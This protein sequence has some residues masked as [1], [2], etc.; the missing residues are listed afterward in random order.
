MSVYI[1]IVQCTT[2]SFSLSLSLFTIWKLKTFASWEHGENRSEMMYIETCKMKACWANHL[3]VYEFSFINSQFSLCLS[4]PKSSP[5]SLNG[6]TEVNNEKIL[7]SWCISSYQTLNTLLQGVLC[8]LMKTTRGTVHHMS[9]SSGK[10]R[11]ERGT[12][13]ILIILLE[14][15]PVLKV[16]RT[17]CSLP[18]S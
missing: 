6:V 2:D 8:N 11:H 7:P 16:F 13:R 9:S 10:E 17:T 12:Y 14:I 15:F 5:S 18:V 4:S 3:L 1:L